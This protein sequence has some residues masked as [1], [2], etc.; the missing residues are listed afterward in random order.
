MRTSEKKDAIQNECGLCV[1]LLC[2][3]YSS[4]RLEIIFIG[5]F[6]I[7]KIMSLIYQLHYFMQTPTVIIVNNR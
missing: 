5:V 6:E 3:N 2:I 1:C 7:R 4:R